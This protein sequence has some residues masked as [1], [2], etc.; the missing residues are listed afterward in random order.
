MKGRRRE[1]GK[2]SRARR[3]ILMQT[4]G[5]GGGDDTNICPHS[6]STPG[7]YFGSAVAAAAVGGGGLP[8]FV[9]GVGLVG[10]FYIRHPRRRR[11]HL[12]RLKAH[13][14]HICGY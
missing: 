3:I 6:N 8:V 13:I 7:R 1:A 10:G 4:M 5:W 14:L 11:L 9:F 12:Q 2:R